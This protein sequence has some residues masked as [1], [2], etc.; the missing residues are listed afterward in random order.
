MPK[1]VVERQQECRARKAAK[2]EPS[3]KAGKRITRLLSDHPEKFGKF[4]T[5]MLQMN[6]EVKDGQR[7]T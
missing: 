1:T 2:Q 4:E 3:K 5:F 6:R 7:P